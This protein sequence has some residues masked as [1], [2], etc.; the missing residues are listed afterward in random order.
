MSCAGT[1]SET[2]VLN[3]LSAQEKSVKTNEFT[4][5]LTE[6]YKHMQELSSESASASSSSSASSSTI[7][8]DDDYQEHAHSKTSNVLSYNF[9]V[10]MISF[11]DSEKRVA[12]ISNDS[13]N[14][15]PFLIFNNDTKSILLQVGHTYYLVF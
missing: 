2:S 13:Q 15:S 1:E 4:E 10:I 9:Q 8:P 7:S 6:F 12:P 5:R 11:D 14:S 3:L